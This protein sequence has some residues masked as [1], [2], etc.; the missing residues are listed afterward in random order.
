MYLSHIPEQSDLFSFFLF[1]E[2]TSHFIYKVMKIKMLGT[3]CFIS[4]PFHM[5]SSSQFTFKKNNLRKKQS[6]KKQVPIDPEKYFLLPK[7][8]IDM[9][10]LTYKN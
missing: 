8:E 2:A 9:T 5:I 1:R 7:F 3:L 4:S 10:I 6:K